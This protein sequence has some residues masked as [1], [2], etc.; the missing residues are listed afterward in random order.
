[1]LKRNFWNKSDFDLKMANFGPL[2]VWFLVE[3]WSDKSLILTFLG[4]IFCLAALLMT[5]WTDRT[6]QQFV[7]AICV[8]S[9]S[10]TSRLGF[11]STNV[12][13]AKDKYW[14]WYFLG[15]PLAERNPSLL[16]QDAKKMTLYGK[17]LEVPLWMECLRRSCCQKPLGPASTVVLRPSRANFWIF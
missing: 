8:L 13:P 11:N 1:M 3:I 2:L 6:L 9:I 7:S 17:A 12:C 16:V 14:P 4:L 5:V 15:R 10:R